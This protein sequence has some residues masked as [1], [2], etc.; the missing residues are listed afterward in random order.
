MLAVGIV[1]AGRIGRRLANLIEADARGLKLAGMVGRTPG[2]GVTARLDDLI[3]A[4]PAVIV[5][6]ASRAAL[7]ELGPAILKA[8]VDLIPLSLTAFADERVEAALLE[9]A[10]AGPGRLEIPPG[11]IGTLDLLATAREAG[12][13][14]VTYRQCKSAAMWKLTPAAA[15]A[16]LDAVRAR[17]VILAGSVREVARRFPDNLNVSVGVALAGLGL[18]RTRIELVAD[19]EARETSHELDIEAPPGNARLRLGGR[20]VEPDGDP[21]DYSTFSLM[22][23]LRR[24]IARIVF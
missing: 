5:E 6:C 18:D 16:D 20:T 24:R 19:P 17:T 3:A 7:A 15:L 9:A 13:A 8:G 21:V 10:T 12:L 14:A 4:R 23:L 1:G 2:A 22:R 11:A